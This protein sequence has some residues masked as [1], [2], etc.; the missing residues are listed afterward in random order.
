[1]ADNDNNGGGGGG[2][3]CILRHGR[4]SHT[5]GELRQATQHTVRDPAVSWLGDNIDPARSHLNEVLVGTGD[6][7][8]DVR[9]R[10]ATVGLEP[11]AGQVV[12]RELLVTA[13]HAYFGGDGHSGRDGDW[14]Q[15]RLAAWKTATVDFLQGEFGANLVT[16][17]L[18]LDE[19]VPHAH[20]WV[21]TAVKVEK[22][23]RGRPRKDGTKA[24]PVMGWTLNHDKVM[25]NGKE[26]FAARQDRYA[27]AMEPL[28]LKRGH[29]RLVQ[30]THLLFELVPQRRYLGRVALHRGTDRPDADAMEGIDDPGKVAKR[31]GGVLGDPIE[32]VVHSA[33]PVNAEPTGGDQDRQHNGGQSGQPPSNVPVEI[34]HIPQGS[35]IRHKQVVCFLEKLYQYYGLCISVKE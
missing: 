14:D 11:K 25:G 15:E 8:D 23:G 3:F 10:L 22:Q 5:W 35:H 2:P 17:T 7:V 26:A 21:T 28:G 34:H 16:V 33:Q 9:T 32:A 19:S 6:V 24:A 31:L 13:S 4:K 29:P 12:A 30:I 20:V 18:H 27:D 1:M